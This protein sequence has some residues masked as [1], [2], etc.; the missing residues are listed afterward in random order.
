MLLGLQAWLGWVILNY[1]ALC[2]GQHLI[3]DFITTAFNATAPSA[4]LLPAGWLG[5]LLLSVPHFKS[6]YKRGLA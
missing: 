6:G 4:A 5:H 3:W 1:H 2:G